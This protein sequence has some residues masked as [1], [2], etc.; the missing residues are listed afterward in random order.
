MN[1]EEEGEQQSADVGTVHIGI[2]H[3]D[4]L[5][6]PQLGCQIHPRCRIPKR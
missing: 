5:A 1:R 3:D 4:Y 6:I 2:G